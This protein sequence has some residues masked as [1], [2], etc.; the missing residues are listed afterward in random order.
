MGIIMQTRNIVI[1]SRLRDINSR[2]KGSDTYAMIGMPGSNK[3]VWA[4]RIDGA[5][6]IEDNYPLERSIRSADRHGRTLLVAPLPIGTV[7]VWVSKGVG[8]ERS[9]KWAR[10]VTETDGEI[11]DAGEIGA[12]HVRATSLHILDVASR[13][14]GD[15]WVTVVN[16]VEYE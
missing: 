12:G 6:I 10:T 7:I 5:E 4:D 1:T 9:Q 3:L 14:R 13:R 2:G 11:I 15:G 8:G 16:G